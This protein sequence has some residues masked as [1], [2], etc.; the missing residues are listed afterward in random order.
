MMESF[1]YF[2]TLVYRDER[3]DFID[4][5]LPLCNARL[6]EVRAVDAPVCQSG[7]LGRYAEAREL[8]DY[9]LGSSIEILRSQGYAVERYD[10]SVQ[11]LWAQEVKRG[12]GTNIHVHKN[13][14]I[15]GWFFLE[16]AEGGAY[17]AYHDTRMNKNMIELDYMQGG[18]VTVAT[19]SIH[20]SNIVP[21]T[22]LFSNAW[23]NHQLVGGNSEQPVKCI[24]FIIT[25]KDKPCSTC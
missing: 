24:H 4:Q 17:P 21:G 8:S 2:P 18:D 11:G 1:A 15:C 22:V 13:S 23:V 9:L 5:V 16:A 6:D 10:F 7:H 14:Q 25:H 20:F 3:P 19:S 12:G